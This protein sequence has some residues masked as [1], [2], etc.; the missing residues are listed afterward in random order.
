MA[1]SDRLAGE[2]SAKYL[3]FKYIIRFLVTKMKLRLFKI[4]SSSSSLSLALT[5]ALA[6]F[7]NAA[8]QRIVLTPGW[9]IISLNVDPRE[10][11]REGEERGPDIELMFA[12]LQ[13]GERNLLDVLQDDSSRLYRPNL[14]IR[15]IPYWNLTRGYRAK[16]EEQVELVFEGE[17]IPADAPII[18]NTGWNCIAYYPNYELPASLPDFYVLSPIIANVIW[19]RDERGSFMKP[20]F[21]FSNMRPWRPGRGYLVEVDTIVILHYPPPLSIK[22]PSAPQQFSILSLYPN[23]FNSET[24]LKYSI[25][26][27][28]EIKV[29]IVDVCGRS[30]EI[31]FE[32]SLNNGRY[33]L[34]WNAANCPAG[35]YYFRLITSYRTT[36]TKGLLIR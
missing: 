11:Y 35:I 26:T 5:L 19:A 23:P 32:G 31:L 7:A 33:E 4:S 22:S 21:P 25:S 36:I 18:L 8:E 16:P 13:R 27:P 12:Q 3:I 28:S 17:T 20:R 2:I 30:I 14:G 1:F 6:I 10:M 34:K 15:E 9:N 24:S 29:D